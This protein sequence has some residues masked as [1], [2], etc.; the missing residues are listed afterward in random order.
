MQVIVKSEKNVSGTVRCFRILT[1]IPISNIPQQL[2]NYKAHPQIKWN[3][4]V[5]PVRSNRS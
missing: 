2:T 3:P 5:A 4:C 1:W